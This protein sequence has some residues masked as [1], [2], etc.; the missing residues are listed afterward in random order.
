MILLSLFVLNINKQVSNEVLCMTP[1]LLPVVTMVPTHSHGVVAGTAS[2]LHGDCC[3][4]Y[5]HAYMM[6]YA[7]AVEM[8]RHARLQL[9]LQGIGRVLRHSDD[10]GVGIVILA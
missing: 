4:A 9:M 10:L 8:S 6:R 1:K 7:E 2:F 3:L 5:V